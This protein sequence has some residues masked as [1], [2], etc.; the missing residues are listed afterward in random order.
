MNEPSFLA[1]DLDRRVEAFEAAWSAGGP[2]DLEQFLPPSSDS[3]HL[4]VLAELI[5]VDLEL[6]FA[7]GESAR[8]DRY[9][10]IFPALFA[11]P[12]RVAEV[13]FEEYRLRAVAGERPRPREYAL[14]YRI[15][16]SSW[17]HADS[18]PFRDEPG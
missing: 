14:R 17:P 9:E 8:L 6:R 2:P 15:D 1:P 3:A 4:S 18:A 12:R 5:R 11:D 7:C 13:A 10:F 16:T